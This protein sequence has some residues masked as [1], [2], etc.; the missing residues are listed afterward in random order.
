MCVFKYF[1]NREKAN[2]Q[3]ILNKLPK[4]LTLEIRQP[5]CIKTLHHEKFQY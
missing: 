5:T 3:P 4:L 1:W 2:L